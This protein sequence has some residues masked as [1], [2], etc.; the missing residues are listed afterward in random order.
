MTFRAER[1]NGENVLTAI[2]VAPACHASSNASRPMTTRRKAILWLGLC[3]SLPGAGYASLGF[4]YFTWLQGLEQAPAGSAGLLAFA[5]LALAALCAGVFI[6]CLLSL[7]RNA[8]R[9]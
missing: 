4:V 2:H 9:A 8:R 7:I 1:R 3:L 5:M 6:H